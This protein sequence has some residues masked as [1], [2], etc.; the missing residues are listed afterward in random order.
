MCLDYWLL[1]H[2]LGPMAFWSVSHWLTH[3]A[4]LSSSTWDHGILVWVPSAHS[5]SSVPVQYPSAHLDQPSSST[6]GP[7]AFRSGCPQFTHLA[8]PL[9]S[10]WDQLHSALRPLSS[11]NGIRVQYPSVHSNCPSSSTWDYRHSS[12]GSLSSLIG[13]PLFPHLGSVAFWSGVPCLTQQHS[14]TG[15]LSS[16]IW[17]AIL[18]PPGTQWCSCLGT[19]GSAEFWSRIP[20]LTHSACPSSS[21]FL[22]SLGSLTRLAHIP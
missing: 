8:C 19:L 22:S 21:A 7:V 3:S 6:P 14:S 20:Q 18:P 11:L 1:F 17:P 13:L 9:S 2:H 12:L 15:I 5:L 4:H 16:L 10:T